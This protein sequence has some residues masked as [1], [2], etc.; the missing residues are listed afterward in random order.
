MQRTANSLTY[1]EAGE[2]ARLG[3]RRRGG[4][5]GGVDLGYKACGVGHWIGARSR[6]DR[7][8]SGSTGVE[9][10]AGI[11]TV[12]FGVRSSFS[13]LVGMGQLGPSA[14]HSSLLVP[15]VLTIFY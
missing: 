3:P 1:V 6:G 8:A 10:D 4:V 5:G 15:S 9:E 12:L 7:A 2:A 11:N 14:F 13:G